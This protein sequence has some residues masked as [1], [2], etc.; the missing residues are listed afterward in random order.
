MTSAAGRCGGSVGNLAGYV[1]PFVVGK[2]RDATHSMTLA[3]TVLSI[4]VM[5]A[6]LVVIYVTAVK[7][8]QLSVEP[9]P[10]RA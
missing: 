6:G 2:I 5:I 4:S 7:P 1:S 8:K 9:T 3:L 10:S